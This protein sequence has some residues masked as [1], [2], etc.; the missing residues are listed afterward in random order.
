MWRMT[1]SSWGPIPFRTDGTR[2]TVR[3]DFTDGKIRKHAEKF[4]S[5]WQDQ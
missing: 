1:F 2:W 4:F 3:Q 5:S